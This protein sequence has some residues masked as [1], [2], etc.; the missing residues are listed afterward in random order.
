MAGSSCSAFVREML[1]DDVAPYTLER[2]ERPDDSS[3]V[4]T[5]GMLRTIEPSTCTA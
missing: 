5:A 3:T 4:T 2:C 1:D